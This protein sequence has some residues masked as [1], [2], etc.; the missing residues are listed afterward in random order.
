MKKLIAAALSL[1]LVFANTQPIMAASSSIYEILVL[2]NLLTYDSDETINESA[3]LSR[4]EFAKALYLLAGYGT[5][6]SNS[7]TSPFADVPY[8]N[9]YAGYIKT[10]T[11]LGYMSGYAKGY[12]MPS[13]TITTNEAIKALLLVLGYSTNEIAGTDLLYQIARVKGLLDNTSI[14]S[15]ASLTKGD[16]AQLIYN[17]LSATMK[18]SNQTLAQTI[19]YTLRSDSLSLSDVIDVNAVGPIA[20]T[21]SGSA[22]DFG[23]N[24]PITY[25]NGVEKSVSLRKGDVVYYSIETNK[26]WVY[27]NYVYGTITA[28]SSNLEDVTSFTAGG[29]Y[30]CSTD[31]IK[32]LFAT[33]KLRVGYPVR[34]SLDRDGNAAYASYYEQESDTDESSNANTNSSGSN[35]NSSSSTVVYVNEGKVYLT[36]DGK[37]YT[38]DL[39]D[40]ANP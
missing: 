21:G 5:T 37:T 30:S 36:V 13:Q 34:I 31:V 18:T 15:N 22:S 3:P 35:S 26:M 6:A 4:A 32:N 28:I 19:G 23:L 12:F 27:R 38:F 29:N 40:S 1:L 9:Q 33:N 25:L 11:S 14:T 20:I 8:S 7:Y 2:M 17:A 39:D 24:S 10:V 16:Y